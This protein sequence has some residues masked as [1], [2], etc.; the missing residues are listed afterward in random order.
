MKLLW[1][2]VVSTVKMEG[3]RYR[4]SYMQTCEA[5]VSTCAFGGGDD[6]YQR[7]GISFSVCLFH[8]I[9]KL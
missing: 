9:A 5:L 1:C 3:L 4:M 8:F 6:L 2:I 7:I